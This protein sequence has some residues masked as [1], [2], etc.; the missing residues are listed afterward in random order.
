MCDGKACRPPILIYTACSHA[1][2][3]CE[4]ISSGMSLDNRTRSR[5]HTIRP[6][7]KESKKKKKKQF[8]AD[9]PFATLAHSAR[10]TYPSRRCECRAV[11]QR[12]RLDREQLALCS[13]AYLA[14]TP[15]SARGAV[16][17]RIYYMPASSVRHEFY[18]RRKSGTLDKYGYISVCLF[19]TRYCAVVL[20]RDGF[21]GDPLLHWWK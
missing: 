2:R 4:T 12:R 1:L 21:L 14:I 17:T 7:Q 19:L 18:T 5:C 16:A 20:S 8:A 10:R 9:S 13:S 3:T 6:R 15:E 11:V